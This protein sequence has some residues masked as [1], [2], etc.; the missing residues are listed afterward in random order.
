MRT[1]PH[2]GGGPALEDRP[3]PC[4]SAPVGA[5][6]ATASAHGGFS[7]PRSGVAGP[8]VVMRTGPHLGG[9]PALEDQPR[10]CRSVPVGAIL[11]TASAHGGFSSP[12]SSARC[13]PP[14]RGPLWA[15]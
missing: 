6:S 5:I 1:G 13:R 15:Y 14:G 4:R 7:S 10:P 8:V 12:R 2:L 3:R 11:A 9:G